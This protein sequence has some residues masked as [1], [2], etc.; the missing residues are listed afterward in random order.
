VATCTVGQVVHT[1]P[2][3]GAVSGIT[4]FGEEIHVLRWQ[5]GG[6][7]EIEVYDV[8]NYRLQRRISVPFCRRITDMTSC[9]HYRCIYLSDPIA[10]CVHR[11]H[12]Q[13]QATRWEV[14]DQ[15]Q[16]LS[17]NGARN[18]LVTCPSRVIKEFSTFGEL[19]R[20]IRLPETVVNPW[21]AKQ[22]TTG[23]FIVCH[24]KVE[25]ALRRVCKVSADGNRIVQSKRDGSD[26]CQH[27][28]PRHLA[29]D[30]NQFVFVADIP[31][32][33]VTLMSPTL[34]YVHE[35]VTGSQLK[36]FPYRIFLDV[37]RKRLYVTDNE[38]EDGTYKSERVVVFSI[39]ELQS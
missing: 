6:Q 34:G 4:L 20:E 14:A 15:P 2:E 38:F 27:G 7:A 33:R 1:L 23:E 12:V 19:V 11:L 37:R 9:E 10:K 26:T 16:G 32:R 17:V 22:L 36:W 13:G 29:V 21:H 39:S 28:V 35:V 31:N 3:G 25:D 8:I 24:G 30:Q 18:L 5:L